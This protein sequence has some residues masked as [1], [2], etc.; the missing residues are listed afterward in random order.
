MLQGE[1]SAILLTFINLQFVIKI[2]VLSIFESPFYTGFIVAAIARLTIC[3]LM[4]FPIHIDTIN[5]GLS[6]LWF[7]GSQVEGSKSVF[8]SLNVV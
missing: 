4:D 7:K 8:L 6:I 2:F 5:M 3:I 1:Y